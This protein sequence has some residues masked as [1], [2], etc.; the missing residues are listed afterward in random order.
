MANKQYSP[1]QEVEFSK[2]SLVFEVESGESYQV[3]PGTKGRV[4]E[5]RDK[6]EIG[7]LW[8]QLEKEGGEKVI[9]R[10]D[11]KNIK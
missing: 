8:I 10:T 6:G 1:G 4:V 2:K 5:D 3:N 9:V 11:D 7:S